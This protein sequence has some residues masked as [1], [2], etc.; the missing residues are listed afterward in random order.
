MLEQMGDVQVYDSI[1]T[2]EHLHSAFEKKSRDISAVKSQTR[3]SKPDAS[4]VSPMKS[5]AKS[6]IGLTPVMA[7]KRGSFTTDPKRVEQ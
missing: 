1:N 2:K 7:N 5:R 6:A 3:K 4:D